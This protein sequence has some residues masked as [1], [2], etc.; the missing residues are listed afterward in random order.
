[1]MQSEDPLN[2][3]DEEDAAPELAK[4]GF[5]RFS[6]ELS[7]QKAAAVRGFCMRAFLLP[8]WR[9]CFYYITS[10]LWTSAFI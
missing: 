9:A 5:F 10:T 2:E 6:G 7:V 1:M 3:E 4:G 8:D